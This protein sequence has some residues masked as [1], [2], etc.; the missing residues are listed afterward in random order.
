MMIGI[1]VIRKMTMIRNKNNYDH[2]YD[3]VQEHI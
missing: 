1:I 3:A 2:D